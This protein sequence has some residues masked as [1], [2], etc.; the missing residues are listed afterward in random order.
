MKSLS[1]LSIVLVWGLNS[2]CVSVAAEWKALSGI[3]HWPDSIRYVESAEGNR[4]FVVS[5]IYDGEPEKWKRERGYNWTMRRLKIWS[6]TDSLAI[7]EGT[8]E[9]WYFTE[10]TPLE[11][12]GKFKKI[13]I[14]SGCIPTYE[15]LTARDYESSQ[16]ERG[17][18]EMIGQYDVH[19]V[20]HLIDVPSACGESSLTFVFV[21]ARYTPFETNAVIEY[22]FSGGPSGDISLTV[23]QGDSIPYSLLS[24]YSYRK[25][26]YAVGSFRANDTGVAKLIETHEHCQGHMENALRL[27]D[28]KGEY[29]WINEGGLHGAR[30]V[31]AKDITG[32]GVDELFVLADDHG[33]ERVVVF[34]KAN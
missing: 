18:F 6:A 4:A 10:S 21:Q 20:G 22:T 16:L 15:E 11:F 24:V 2:T 23:C 33:S 32:D 29:Y 8:R 31:W 19:G 30:G 13:S 3:E 1:L 25:P 34:G 9:A 27:F 12:L 17:L 28:G 26:D 5:G 7:N 14:Y